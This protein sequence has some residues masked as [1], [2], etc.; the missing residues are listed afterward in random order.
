MTVAPIFVLSLP[1]SGST[2]VQRLL[3]AHDEISTT[4]EP[5]LLLPQIYAMRER[6]IFAEYGQIPSA[7]AIREFAARLPNGEHDYRD[8]LRRFVLALYLKAS[9]DNGS[10]FLDKTPRYHFIIH[11]LVQLFPDAKYVYLWRNP[12]AVAAS[13]IQTWCAGKWK[14][15]RWRADLFDGLAHIVDAYERSTPSCAVRYED[16]VMD[17]LTAWP[18]LFEYLQLPFDDSLLNSF[19][20]VD[21]EGRMGDRTGSQRYDTISTAPIDKWRATVSN[22]MRKRWFR[23]YLEW[24]GERRLATMGYDLS[25]LTDELDRIPFGARMLGS[26]LVRGS[27]WKAASQRRASAARRLTRPPTERRRGPF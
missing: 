6:G 24:I 14:I 3:A 16:L 15:E 2:L 1:R 4:P 7:R 8:E 25:S 26:D 5:W 18:P 17:P 22:P 10:Y 19:G 13:I 21:L 11:E 12:L 23:R 9:E 20:S 27:Y